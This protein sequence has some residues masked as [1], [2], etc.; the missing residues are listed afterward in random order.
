MDD[1]ILTGDDEEE[2]HRTGENLSICI[3]MKELCQLKHFL[4]LEV[5]R[6]KEDD[7][8]LPIEIYQ[9]LVEEAWNVGMLE[10]KLISTQIEVNVKLCA[11]EGKYLQDEIIYQ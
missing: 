4:S 11:H 3:Q 6:T 8:S 1:L 10:C 7:I 2:I 5:D 9:R